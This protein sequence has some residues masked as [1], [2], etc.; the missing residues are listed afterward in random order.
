MRRLDRML[1][2]MVFLIAVLLG[3]FVWGLVRYIALPA[4]APT[5]TPH[6]SM[7]EKG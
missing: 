7:A 5:P 1:L 4:V 6:A 3:V 2:P